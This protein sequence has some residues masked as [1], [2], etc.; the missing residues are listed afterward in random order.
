MAPFARRLGLLDERGLPRQA[1][2]RHVSVHGAVAGAAERIPLMTL[3]YELR[4]IRRTVDDGV[5]E[6]RLGCAVLAPPQG[7]PLPGRGALRV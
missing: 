5:S 4:G 6:A 2:V 3:T 7:G 1:R